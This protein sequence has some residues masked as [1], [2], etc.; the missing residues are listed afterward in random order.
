MAKKNNNFSFADFVKELKE[1]SV[2][3]AE[4]IE[5]LEPIRYYLIVCEGEKTEPNYFNMYQSLLP[6]NVVSM[7]IIGEGAETIRVVEKAIAEKNRR[8]EDPLNPPYDQVWA[9][10]DK[11]DF[12]DKNFNEAIELAKRND[13]KA[14]FS[15][16]AFE[17]WYILHFQRLDSKITRS[18]YFR[19]ISEILKVNYTKNSD[20]IPHQIREIGDVNLAIRYARDLEQ[21]FRGFTP[22]QSWPSTQVYKLIEDFEK[23]LHQN[24]T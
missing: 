14:G 1:T 3:G 11:D 7:T 9:V 2:L 21:T 23:I 5:I 10:F 22:S 19:I 17:L 24:N 8:L 13:I 12:P 18:D 20:T 4:E 16:Q 15:N 6:K